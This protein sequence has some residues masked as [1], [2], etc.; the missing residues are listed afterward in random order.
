MSKHILQVRTILII[1]MGMW[2][3]IPVSFSQVPPITED[4]AR[5]MLAERG[6]PED[7]LRA[8]LLKKGYD[9]DS[10][11][12]D[13]IASFQTVILQTVSEIEA[14]MAIREQ[15]AKLKSAP[16]EEGPIVIPD[17]QA[18]EDQKNLLLHLNLPPFTARKFF[19][20]IPLPFIKK[21]MISPRRVIMSLVQVT[22]SV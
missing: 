2:S 17:K 19:E 8:R 15:S 3:F 5:A 9:P 7:T 6:I 10:I 20:T 11:A 22:Y 1:L 18:A 4:Q 12:P 16:R 13:Q 14:D 21:Q